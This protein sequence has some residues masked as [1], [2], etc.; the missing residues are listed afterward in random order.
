[1]QREL[2]VSFSE[3][4]SVFRTM[5]ENTQALDALQQGRAVVVRL[6]GVSPDNP[7]WKR[8]LAW[9][10]GQIAELTSAGTAPA[11]EK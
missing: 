8:D 2:A 11:S 5:G 10:D 9:F 6:T 7:I 4:A 3:L 1:L